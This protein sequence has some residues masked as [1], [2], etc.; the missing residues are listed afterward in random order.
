[1][2]DKA[3]IPDDILAGAVDL[4]EAMESNKADAFTTSDE[5]YAR[6]VTNDANLIARIWKAERAKW[7]AELAALRARAEKA[8]READ[9]VR[10]DDGYGIGWNSGFE[11]AI[12]ETL[13]LNFPTMLRKMWSGGEVQSWIDEKVAIAR[14]ALKGGAQ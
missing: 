6:L 8:E 9:R 1:M 4:I 2:N 3:P 5:R 11:H 12:K 13:N 7:E 10:E 14:A